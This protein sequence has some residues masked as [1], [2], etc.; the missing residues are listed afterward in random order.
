MMPRFKI[1]H[2]AVI[3]T[4]MPGC[5]MVGPDYKRPE[6][7]VPPQYSSVDPV[8]ASNEAE[9]SGTWW[10][11]YQ[12]PVLNE[13]VEKALKNNTDVKLAVAKVEESDAYL[14]EVGAALLPEIDLDTS[15]SRSRVSQI[16]PTP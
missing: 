11:L 14:R 2:L 4:L 16:G 3:A 5:M 7:K 12:D 13:L 6:A 1:A 10:Q 9:V 15:G 8:Q